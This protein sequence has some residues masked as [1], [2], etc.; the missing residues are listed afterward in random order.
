MTQG[1]ICQIL[2][3]TFFSCILREANYLYKKQG[4]NT[5]LKE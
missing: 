4:E 2:Q 5:K 1:E 3:T